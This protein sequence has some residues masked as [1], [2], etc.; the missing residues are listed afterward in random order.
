M[1]NEI[2][3]DWVKSPAGRGYMVT[4]SDLT[5]LALPDMSRFTR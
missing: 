1:S 5:M 2:F 3:G 4:D